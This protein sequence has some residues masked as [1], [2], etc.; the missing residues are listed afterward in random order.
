MAATDRL[1]AD[2]A[3]Q[4]HAHLHSILPVAQ[5]PE[6]LPEMQWSPVSTLQ[7][8]CRNKQTCNSSLKDC[9]N[10]RTMSIA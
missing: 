3:C 2:Q 8:D 4:S 5:S 7:S 10:G 6:P 9:E 1:P